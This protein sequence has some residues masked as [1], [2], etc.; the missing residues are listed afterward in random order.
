MATRLGIICLV[1]ALFAGGFAGIVRYTDR[2]EDGVGY[3]RIAT[4]P[5]CFGPVMR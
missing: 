5:G 4:N 3:C 2:H 1:T